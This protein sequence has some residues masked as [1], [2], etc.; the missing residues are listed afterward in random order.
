MDARQDHDV[1][2]VHALLDE[3][4][5]RLPVDRA[6][7]YIAGF[8]NGGLMTQQLAC[9]T[10]ERFAGMAVIAQTLHTNLEAICAPPAHLPMLYMVGTRDRFWE[11]RSFSRS[12]PETLDFWL[13]QSGCTTEPSRT[14]ALR[15]DPSDSTTVTRHVYD[16]CTHVSAIEFLRIDN[17]GHSWPGAHRAEPNHCRD[18]EATEEV[19]GFFR[20]HAGL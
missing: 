11:A 16:Q 7:I 2:F 15:D 8:S 18:V 12:A 6:R 1:T 17:G 19:L 20:R 10:P 13:G 4:E 9:K 14:V 5:A 3:L